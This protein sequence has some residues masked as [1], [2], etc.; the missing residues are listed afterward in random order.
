MKK[1]KNDIW[2]NIMEFIGNKNFIFLAL[3]KNLK[4]IYLNLFKNYETNINLCCK[5]PKLLEFASNNNFILNEKIMNICAKQNYIDSLKYLIKMKC[6]YARW[7]MYGHAY[8]A[9]NFEFLKI[10]RDNNL[11]QV[12]EYA[13]YY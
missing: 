2:Y 1:L 11:Y 10:M 9:K 13:K 4:I 3:N 6:P 12:I 7:T 5:S 8:C